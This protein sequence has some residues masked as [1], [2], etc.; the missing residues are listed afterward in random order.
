MDETRR[1]C[2]IRTDGRTCLAARPAR[3]QFF[4]RSLLT[5]CVAAHFKDSRVAADGVGCQRRVGNGR[6]DAMT[7]CCRG[8][9]ETCRGRPGQRAWAGASAY[10]LDRLW[11]VICTVACVRVPGKA[12]RP[13]CVRRG[14]GLTWLEGGRHHLAATDC[15]TGQ[16]DWQRGRERA[17]ISNVVGTSPSHRQS[18]I[19]YS[20][21]R[22]LLPPHH[23]RRSI[24]VSTRRFH[25]LRPKAW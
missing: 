23:I 6:T 7:G 21:V 24:R 12:R 3:R 17:I 1:V 19:N 2:H 15:V 11:M 18:L 16:S 13:S 9:S 25:T 10:A 22:T 20:E 4:L 8:P 5:K 14:L